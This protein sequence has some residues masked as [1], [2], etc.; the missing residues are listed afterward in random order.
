VEMGEKRSGV[1]GRLAPR[2][3]T[4]PKCKEQINDEFDSCWKCAGSAEPAPSPLQGKKPLEQFEFVC[5]LIGIMPGIIFFTHGRAQN[6]E[7]A[8]FRIA[9]IIIAFILGFGGYA[10]IKLY[11]R[12]KAR[13][14]K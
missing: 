12:M 8:I 3:W 2:M 11:Q 9:A 4:C 7:Q 6:P 10:G 5:I 1:L 14:T 13:E